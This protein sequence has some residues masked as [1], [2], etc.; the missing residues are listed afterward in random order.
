MTHSTGNAPKKALSFIFL[1]LVLDVTGLGLVIPVLPG[2]IQELGGVE[3]SQ[4]SVIGGWLSFAYAAMQFICSPILGALSDRFGRRPILLVSLAGLGVD[5]F[6]M[7]L[8]PQLSWLFFGKVIAGIGGA[9]FTTATAYIADISTPQTRA[10]NFGLVGAAFGIGFILGPAIGGFLGQLDVR[11]PFYFAAGLSLLNLVYGYFVLPESLD[12][13]HRR[14]F[15]WKRANPLGTFRQLAQM[16]AIRGLL[17]AYFLLFLGAN[18]VQS[19]WSFFTM[20]RFDWPPRTVGLSLGLAGVMVGLVQ[21]LLIRRINPWLGNRKSV[22]VGLSF[23]AAGLLMFALASQGW[24]MFAILV[25][26]A[27]GGISGPAMQAIMAGQVEPNAQGELQA[28]ITSL[29][30]LTQIIGPILMT[31]L[32]ERFTRVDAPIAFPGAAFLCGALLVL[33]SVWMAYLTLEK[34]KQH[35]FGKS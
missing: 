5:Y 9:S 16:P 17:I 34:N 31:G 13:A 3:M 6:L 33:M 14:T 28:G 24:M 22:Y 12:E 15:S 18:S 11:A 10:Q 20:Y 21:G 19:T 8:A 29:V 25:P 23:Y 2:L 35:G 32:F 27:F 1:T 7:S 30:S 26:Y 4:A